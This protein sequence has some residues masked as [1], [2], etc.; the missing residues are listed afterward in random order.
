[1]PREA[2]RARMRRGTYV[3]LTHFSRG[4]ALLLTAFLIVACA[5]DAGEDFKPGFGPTS[6][7]SVGDE[8]GDGSTRAPVDSAAPSETSTVSGCS[9][10]G[11]ALCDGNCVDTTSNT[12]NCGMC[13]NMCT[14]NVANAQPECTSGVCA[15][16]CDA[17]YSVCNGTCSD[18]LTDDSNCGGCG[19]T[20]ACASGTSCN[21]GHCA[22]AQADSGV[23]ASADT[24]V[25]APPPM[26]AALDAKMDAAN[27]ADA[28]TCKIG[29]SG[30]SCGKGTCPGCCDSSGNCHPGTSNSDC[31]SGSGCCSDCST[32]S[33]TC[34]SNA[35]Q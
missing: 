23:D 31:G 3:S 28:A 7:A 26:D 9:A 17:G 33:M 34:V 19:S 18:E 13:G 30:S 14:T 4:G 11:S 35:C 6:E 22:S 2:T 29:S 10:T 1:M 21:A 8:L 12:S 20:F 27:K 16:T 25:D 5:A 32:T 24:G 15:F